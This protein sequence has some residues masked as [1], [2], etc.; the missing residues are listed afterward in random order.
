MG[1]GWS[2]TGRPTAP[3]P[4]A[5][6]PYRHWVRGVAW[7][8]CSPWPP[9]WPGLLQRQK[10]E[11]GYRW[12]R[13][14]YWIPSL[15]GLGQSLI[16]RQVMGLRLKLRFRTCIISGSWGE[17]EA[18]SAAKDILILHS[19]AGTCSCLRAAKTEDCCALE[20]AQHLATTVVWQAAE[21][22]L[23]GVP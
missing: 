9:G 14:K 6:E 8:G 5:V 22:E 17:G 4:G 1:L 19:L 18:D 15:V 23:H 20:H 13:G 10:R 16:L 11:G 7:A 21:P 3:P 12:G 2:T